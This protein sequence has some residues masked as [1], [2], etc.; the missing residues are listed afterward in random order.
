MCIRDRLHA[1]KQEITAKYGLEAAKAVLRKITKSIRDLQ[2]FENKGP[3][4]ESLTGIP[5]DYRFLYVRHNYVFY[6]VDSDT[7]W[8]TDIYNEKED[9]MWKLFGIKTITQEAEDYWNG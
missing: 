2:Q 3:S 7:V 9:F 8:I 6:R 4:V 5:C 1:I